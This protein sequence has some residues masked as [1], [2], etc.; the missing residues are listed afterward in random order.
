MSTEHSNTCDIDKMSFQNSDAAG[1]MQASSCSMVQSLRWPVRCDGY[2]R[3]DCG[4]ITNIIHF[5]DLLF[6][7]P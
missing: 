1:C 4:F 6:A 3:H 7:E 2:E 5:N